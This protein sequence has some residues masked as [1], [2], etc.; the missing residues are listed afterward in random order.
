M[1]D[2]AVLA[3][4][5]SDLKLHSGP[6]GRNGEPSW[7]IEDPLRKSFLRLGPLEL[8]ILNR[9]RLR[10]P[11][12]ISH[13]IEQGTL[14]TAS[15]QDV[16]T[17][18]KQLEQNFLLSSAP[19]Q[20]TARA[21]AY[22]QRKAEQAWLR[23]S[24]SYLSLR[25]GLFDPDDFLNTLAPKVSWIFSRSLAF[26]LLTVFISGLYLTTRQW[27]VFL[28]TAPQTFT[29]PGPV[30]LFLTL[31][32]AKSLHE[33]GHAVVAKRAGCNVPTIGVA[34]LVFMPV[35]YT[36]T[37]DAYRL[38]S[39]WRRAQ[40]GL[41]GI[42]TE[43]GLAAIALFLWPFLP[44]GVFKLACFYMCASVVFLTLFVN[45]N[46]LMK[47]DGYYVLSDLTGVEN[48]QER[49]FA[50]LAWKLR[51]LLFGFQEAAPEAQDRLRKWLLF[52]GGAAALYRLFLFFAIAGLIYVFAFKALGL[53]LV[54]VNTVLFLIRPISRF[55][56]TA[57]TMAKGSG[58]RLRPN[59]VTLVTLGALILLLVLPLDRSETVQ[60]ILLPAQTQQIFAPQSGEVQQVHVSQG[61]EVEAGQ[62]L[63]TLSSEEIEHDLRRLG[64][65][66]TAIN[67]RLAQALSDNRVRNELPY[68]RE[69]KTKME[70]EIAA[71]TSRKD[72]LTISALI[73]GTL[74]WG[75]IIPRIG[76]AL[77]RDQPVGTINNIA[78]PRIAAYLSAETVRRL[79]PGGSIELQ[80]SPKEGLVEISNYTV[81]DAAERNLSIPE[82]ASHFGGSVTSGL[83][84]DG[85]LIAQGSVYRLETLVPNVNTQITTGQFATLKVPQE[86]QSYGTAV[87]NRL[88]FLLARELGW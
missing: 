42:A 24:S 17:F 61:E 54:A 9:W 78:E 59:N 21:K 88:S 12:R 68:L 2:A 86:L 62:I 63:L 74:D 4:L 87:L 76:D 69:E 65:G 5:R 56:L 51:A 49:G 26:V 55:F 85:V 25:F 31:L 75:R 15:E 48:L 35:L 81:E 30:A 27:D 28:A 36:E 45:A 44:D 34:F 8:E 60:A 7:V 22:S 11:S 70:E 64:F 53:F 41:A 43:L 16:T 1:S 20:V 73:G 13:D 67:Q 66:L 80:L 72:T 39:R 84:G 58:D 83:D 47:F 82:L 71:V 57:H 10:T 33:L 18:A 14:F 40:I 6:R 46:P 29:P 38:P 50:V 3:P 77:G 37:T 79:I 32:F 23:M 52:Y 19:D